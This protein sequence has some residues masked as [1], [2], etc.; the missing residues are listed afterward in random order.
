MGF[1]TNKEHRTGFDDAEDLAYSPSGGPAKI[2]L[3]GVGLALIPVDY[4]I[5]CLATGHATLWGRY[6]SQLD[7]TGSTAVALA[8]AYIAV[9]VFIHTHWFWGLLPRFEIISYF[10]N[11]WPCSYFLD[12]SDFLFIGLWLH[13][14]LNDLPHT[15]RPHRPAGRPYLITCTTH[16]VTEFA[17][18]YKLRSFP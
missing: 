16:V 10:L 7:V 13:E 18:K 4:G 11:F 15:F 3:L 9:G 6:N 14:S 17:G 1:W 12:A 5:R 2:W 8:I